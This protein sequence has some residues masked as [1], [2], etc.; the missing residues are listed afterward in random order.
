MLPSSIAKLVMLSASGMTNRIDQ[1]V[2][3][4]LVERVVDPDNRRI[5]PVALTAEGV[6]EAERLVRLLV[7]IEEA[8]LDPLSKNE[9]ATLDGLLTKLSA[10]LTS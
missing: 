2:D 9:R 6:A 3:A 4:G 7:D 10:G 8:V 5:A 1:L